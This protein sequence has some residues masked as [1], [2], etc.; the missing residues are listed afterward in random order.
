MRENFEIA[1]TGRFILIEVR[2]SRLFTSR[3]LSYYIASD[4]MESDAM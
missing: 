4:F 3:D 2:F 1:K